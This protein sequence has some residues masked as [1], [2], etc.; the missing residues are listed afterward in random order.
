MRGVNNLGSP[1]Y[2][3]NSA[4]S[5]ISTAIGTVPTGPESCIRVKFVDGPASRCVCL[6]KTT[7]KLRECG[8][9]KANWSM[10]CARDFWGCKSEEFTDVTPQLQ[11]RETLFWALSGPVL[12][13][14]P[15]FSTGR[16]TSP[17][18][19]AAANARPLKFTPLTSLT[20]RFKSR[21]MA[22]RYAW[23]VMRI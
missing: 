9:T 2:C 20:S 5:A 23:M 14:L 17:W 3:Q 19:Q 21:A 6:T 4:P 13:G 15:P 16:H 8:K 18:L 1:F 22:V 10:G 12:P 7:Q 11:A